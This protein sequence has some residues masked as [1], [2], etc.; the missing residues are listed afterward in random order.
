MQSLARDAAELGRLGDNEIILALLLLLLGDR[1]L[2][3]IR[4]FAVTLQLLL[5]IIQHR[6]LT[7]VYYPVQLFFS[8]PLYCSNCMKCLYHVYPLA[9]GRES[10]RD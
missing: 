7:I 5:M 6:A 8:P 4:C 10:E 9:L 2:N 3:V 1:L